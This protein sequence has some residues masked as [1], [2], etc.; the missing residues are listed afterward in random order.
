MTKVRILGISG[1]PRA[2]NTDYAVK[3]AL[4][5]AAELPDVETEFYGFSDKTMNPCTGCWQCSGPDATEQSPCPQWGEDDAVDLAK[6][7]EAF[8]GFVVGTPIYIGTVT[9]QLKA[10]IDR[11]VQITEGGRLGPTSLRNKACG[12][13][14]TSWDR[15]GGH[16]IA[17]VD[18]WRWAIL[19][20]M[21]VVGCGPDKS[22][23]GVSMNNYWGACVI[24]HFTPDHPDGGHG[25]WWDEANGPDELTAVK[26]DKMGLVNCRRLGKRVT[27]MAKV[28]KAGFEVLPDGATAWP[29]GKAGGLVVPG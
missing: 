22:A 29:A 25:I 4:A 1:S 20:D 2:G 3:E 7:M 12:A 21:V 9:A 14:V 8:D 13:V 19:H 28:I 11:A 23:G 16:D 17:I 18:I 26:F 15:N 24:Q 5:G 10:F 6:K 27:E